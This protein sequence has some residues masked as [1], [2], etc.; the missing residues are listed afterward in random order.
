MQ[1]RIWIMIRKVHIDLY[2]LSRENVTERKHLE[3]IRLIKV[4]ILQPKY[5]LI[6]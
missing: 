5:F 1:V 2:Q 4:S 6:R 3:Q